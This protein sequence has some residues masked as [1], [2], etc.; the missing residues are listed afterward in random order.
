MVRLFLLRVRRRCHIWSA[1]GD[2]WVKPIAEQ[3]DDM[4]E[5]EHDGKV[6]AVTSLRVEGGHDTALDGINN[7]EKLTRLEEEARL[8]R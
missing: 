6:R 8:A 5:I 2:S 4:S 3:E 1:A 7:P